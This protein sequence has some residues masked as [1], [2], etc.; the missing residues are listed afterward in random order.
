MGWIGGGGRFW[1]IETGVHMSKANAGLLD[2]RG[3][4][5]VQIFTAFGKILAFIRDICSLAI[6]DLVLLEHC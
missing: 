4:F 2:N 6:K 5:F 3:L 1:G